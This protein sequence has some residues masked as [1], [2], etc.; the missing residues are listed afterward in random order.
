MRSLLYAVPIGVAAGGSSAFF[1]IL[2]ERATEAFDT[3]P[4]LLFLLPVFAAFTAWLYARYGGASGRGTE[5]VLD[6]AEDPG[7]PIPLRMSPLVLVGTVLTHLG[8]GSA[9]REGTAVQMGGSLADALSRSCPPEDRRRLVAAGIAG[10]FGAVFGTPLAGT[11]FALEAPGPLRPR[12]DALLP[13]AI[14]AWIG[15]LTCIH[16]GVVH[17]DYRTLVGER[18]PLNLASVLMGLAVGLAAGG[19]S[20]LFVL[21]T[22]E[23]K[24]QYARVPDPVVRAAVGG[25]V[26]IFATLF[27]GTR[28]YNGLSLPLLVQ[29]FDEPAPVWAFAV[30]AALTAA[31]LGAGMKGGEVT[32]LFVVGGTLGSAI[33]GLVGQPPVVG[34]ALGF[35]AVFSGCARTP[36]AC[37]LMGI[38]LFG[39]GAAV[40]LALACGVAFATAGKVGIYN[41]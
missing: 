4:R 29:S 41:R 19:A 18:V 7:S 5:L 1:L 30:K 3:D 2:L 10:G 24:R 9:G 34:A 23:A 11:S 40:P 31:T 25:S 32:P 27:L 15:H 37:V 36:V 12:W 13:A 22:H 21:L 20:R 14:A 16:L 28:A 38:E 8:G 26:V 33:A 17:T 39:P 35:C 6:R